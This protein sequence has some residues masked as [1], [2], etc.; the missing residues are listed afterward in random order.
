MKAS[1][2]TVTRSG[3]DG[4]DQLAQGTLAN[5]VVS[6]GYVVTRTVGA[7]T[8]TICTVERADPHMH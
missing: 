3:S 2:P 1:T 6:T 8:T 4:R 5:G 7:S